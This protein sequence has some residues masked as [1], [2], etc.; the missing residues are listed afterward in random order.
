MK[1]LRS[2]LINHLFIDFLSLLDILRDFLLMF[3][4]LLCGF[5]R[6]YFSLI[7]YLGYDSSIAT[8]VAIREKLPT[9]SS[10]T[11]LR[12]TA[13]VTYSILV[14]FPASIVYSLDRALFFKEQFLYTVVHLE[15]FQVSVAHYFSSLI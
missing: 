4:N 14:Y 3:E 9:R 2:L 12:R 1:I 11:F 13:F 5:L 10:Q 8:L 7:S 6:R 15:Y